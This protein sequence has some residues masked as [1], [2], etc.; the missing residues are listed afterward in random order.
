MEIY[1]IAKKYEET[2][3]ALLYPAKP[4][5][6]SKD[7]YS[8]HASYGIA[9]D[10]WEQDNEKW[11][12]LVREYK[13]ANGRINQSFRNEILTALEILDHPKA[14][15]LWEMAYERGHSGGYYEVAQE[16]ERL[17]ELL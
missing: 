8:S 17:A 9:L 15:K 14:S 11:H 3:R 16:A 1:E 7:D 5:K 4:Q 13:D 12:A 2:A 10:Q 6:P